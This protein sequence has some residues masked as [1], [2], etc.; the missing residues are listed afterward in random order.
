MNALNCVSQKQNALQ[1]SVIF[2]TIS[3][4]AMSYVIHI[5]SS[6]NYFRLSPQLRKTTMF[7]VTFINVL[8]KLNYI[9]IVEVCDLIAFNLINEYNNICMWVCLCSYLNGWL[10]HTVF[11]IIGHFCYRP[12]RCTVTNTYVVWW[13]NYNERMNFSWCILYRTCCE[14]H[15]FGLYKLTATSN[16]STTWYDGNPSTYR[17]WATGQPNENH[18][19]I[20]Y[21]NVNRKFYDYA[22]RGKLL[23]T[24]K[25]TTGSLS[26]FVMSSNLIDLLNPVTTASNEYFA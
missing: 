10:N 12:F 7:I 22:C 20:Y 25:K 14:E 13:A 2:P 6:A 4:S 5:I 23:Y 9:V 17:N 19:C 18:T 26:V 16:G 24:C 11:Q 1:K 3:F 8:L 15:W 21:F